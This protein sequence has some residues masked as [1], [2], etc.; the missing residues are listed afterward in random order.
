LTDVD[1]VVIS[2]DNFT[3]SPGE[4]RVK[5]GTRVTWVNNDDVPHTIASSGKLF[6]SPPLD[7]GERFSFRSDA[8]GRYEYFCTLHLQMTGII[9]VE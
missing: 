8:D 3:F 1:T 9:V 7:T 2:V 5:S 6:M 4:V